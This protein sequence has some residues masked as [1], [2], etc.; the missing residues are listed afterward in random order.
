MVN[1]GFFV[2]LA[3][4][5]AALLGTGAVRAECKPLFD[6]LERA[7]QQTRMAAYDIESPERVLGRE[8]DV[9]FIGRIGYTRDG[10]DWER[11]EV[12]EIGGYWVRL[13]K[14]LAAGN[15]R[16]TAAGSGTLRGAAASKIS[17]ARP[18]VSKEA[19]SI[20][21]DQRTGLPVYEATANDGGL[22]V[23]YGSAVK[24]PAGAK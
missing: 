22:F 12:G 17:V 4:A 1:P 10:K 23:V 19:T 9:V 13:R 3:F 8:P 6:A 14:E 7:A 21:I 2:R 18:N 24:E 15:V 5:A 20:W 11:V 16:C